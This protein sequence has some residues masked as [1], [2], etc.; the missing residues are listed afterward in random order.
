LGRAIPQRPRGTAFFR[1]LFGGLLATPEVERPDIFTRVAL[2]VHAIAEVRIE[3]ADIAEGNLTID[4][5]EKLYAVGLA[6]E[7]SQDS[8]IRK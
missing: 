4:T 5:W 3:V 6:S 1:R 8:D 2:R 7:L